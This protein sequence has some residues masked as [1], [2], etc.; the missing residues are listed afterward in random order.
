[1][2]SGEPSQLESAGDQSLVPGFTQATAPGLFPLRPAAG[3]GVGVVGS[4]TV[5]KKEC[6]DQLWLKPVLRLALVGH[7]FG[8]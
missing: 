2:D 6:R 3:V 7:R 8:S 1:M 5:K 4:R